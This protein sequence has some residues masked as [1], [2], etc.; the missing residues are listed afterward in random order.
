MGS[1]MV[2]GLLLVTVSCNELKPELPLEAAVEVDNKVDV[3]DN[4]LAN[5]DLLMAFV[6]FRHGDRTPDQEELDKFPSDQHYDNIFFPYGK[7]ALTNKGKQR[8]YRV[9][10]YLRR[11]YN[12]IISS[13]Y[14]PDETHIQTTDYARTKMTVLTALAALFPPPPAQ[15]W[16]P[17]LN[18]QPVPYDT[19]AF[20]DDDFMY[21]YN[22]PRYLQLRDK[23]YAS[24]EFQ[25]R[26]IPYEGLYKYLSI[27]TKTNITTPED[28]FYLDNLFQTL[29]NVGVHPPQWAKEVM[30]KIKEVTK[31]EYAA[32]F[33]T[34]EMIRLAAGVLLEKIENVTGAAIAGEKVIPKLWLFS[35]HE[36]N[37]AALMSAARVFRP[38]QPKY[39]STI[40]LELRKRRL[41]GQYG[42]T[43]VYAAEAGGPGIILPIS[44]CGGLPLCDYDTF[45]SLTREFVLS[46][47]EYKKQCATPVT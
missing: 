15:R 20:E 21:Y 37:V 39:G 25:K 26:M 45:L 23:V 35:A 36:N 31:I 8:G 3:V 16:N 11:R 40:S 32:E 10:E 47:S 30:P 12:N 18:W 42:F 38:H 2:F 17:T 5:T 7:K 19:P 27:K 14:L 43:A 24:P 13:L 33:Y 41:T 29:E 22:C 34:S 6:V 28:V 1:L 9:G 44:G 4:G 46:H